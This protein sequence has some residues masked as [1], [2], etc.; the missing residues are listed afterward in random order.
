MAR[1]PSDATAFAHRDARI[2][3]NLAAFYEG[4]E[5]RI[6]RQAWV[7]DF[8][9]ALTQDGDETAYVNFLGDEGA[10]RVRDAYP[11]ATWD[12]LASVKRRYDPDNVFHRNQNVAPA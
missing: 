10:D 3:V 4:E 5:D 2:M 1:V 8:R 6:E 12:R 9:A 7:D 11:G